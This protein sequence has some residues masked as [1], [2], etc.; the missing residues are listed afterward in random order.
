MAKHKKKKKHT[1]LIL[2]LILLIL[3]LAVVVVLFLAKFFHFELGNVVRSTP[4][5]HFDSEAFSKADGRVTYPGADTGVDVSEHQQEIDWQAVKDDGIS[6]AIIRLGYRGSTKGGLYTDDYFYSNLE[7]AHAAGLDV[8]VYFYS[9]A[10]TEAEAIEEARYVISVLD[11]AELECPVFYDW[12]EGTPR[13]KRL[14]NV[15][16]TDVSDFSAAFC[17]TVESYGYKAG[18]YFNQ[19]Y[20]YGMK[21]Y[22]LTDYD[23]WLAEF[24]DSISF[25]FDT[26]YWQYTYQGTVDGIPL[27][28]DLDLRFGGN[29]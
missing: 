16:L 24:D 10:N 11:G 15:T 18:V 13:A 25:R 9:Q 26:Q 23:F 2:W 4:R 19:K 14:E 8:G 12:E 5:N 6:F 7:G 20:G 21:L 3:L 27:D 17:E 29:G 22:D 28:V 1:G